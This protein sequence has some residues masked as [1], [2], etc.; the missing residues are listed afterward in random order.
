MVVASSTEQSHPY[1]E[2]CAGLQQQNK[3]INSK[4]KVNNLALIVLLGDCLY[5][6]LMIRENNIIGLLIRHYS[7]KAESRNYILVNWKA[8]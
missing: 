1:Y 3:S 5:N 7:R 2:E 8:E 4:L 6:M